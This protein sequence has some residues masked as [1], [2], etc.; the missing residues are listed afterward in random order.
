MKVI[1]KPRIPVQVCKKCGCVAQIKIKDLTL[2]YAGEAKTHFKCPICWTKNEVIFN[3]EAKN[4]KEANI[5]DN[6]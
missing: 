4:D 5:L 2:D 3:E 1:K 6:E